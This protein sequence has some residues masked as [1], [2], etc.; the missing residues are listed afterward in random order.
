[1]IALSKKKLAG[2]LT[3]AIALTLAIVLPLTLFGGIAASP[4]EGFT[5][6]GHVVIEKN[7]EVVYQ[8][9]N[10]MM[11]EGFA[12]VAYYVGIASTDA[13]TQASPV[14][15]TGFL[16]IAVGTDSSE[17][18]VTTHTQLKAEIYTSTTLV[19][20]GYN[21]RLLC[22]GTGGGTGT[23]TV[24]F[25]YVAPSWTIKATF[26][27]ATDGEIVTDE[28]SGDAS[29]MIEAGAALDITE[30]GVFNAAYAVVTGGPTDAANDDAD[31]L[32]CRA[33]FGSISLNDD[34]TLQITWTFELS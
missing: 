5:I 16:W 13:G 21:S 9:D 25:A 30:A 26:I 24:G 34:D 28:G 33:T 23:G 22:D 4:N 12:N 31:D 27:G 6:T 32:L 15:P 7:G 1:M 29:G 2:L 8:S 11:D 17:P 20:P 18:A 3:L 19:D 14:A 10:L